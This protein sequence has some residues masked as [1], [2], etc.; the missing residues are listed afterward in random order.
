MEESAA[1]PMQTDQIVGEQSESTG[2]HREQQIESDEAAVRRKIEEYARLGPDVAKEHVPALERELLAL[3]AR[4]DRIQI[5]QRAEQ[6]ELVKEALE[7]F[8]HKERR[9]EL[10]TG[11]LEECLE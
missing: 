10:P 8:G 5:R 6:K 11:T 4:R 7:M 3:S 2:E 9:A 1:V